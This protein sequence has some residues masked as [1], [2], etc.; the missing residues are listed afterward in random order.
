[1]YSIILFY[2]LSYWIG[3]LN[4]IPIGPV[5]LEIFHTALK[6][7][8]PQALA[9]AF[10]GALGDALWALLAFYGISP[11]SKSHKMEAIFF[12]ITAIITFVLGI[13]ILRDS[14][15]MTRKEEVIVVKIRSKKW[16]FFKG[17]SLIL[18]NPLGIVFWMIVLQF[19]RKMNIYIPLKLNYEIFFFL[20]VAAGAASY[21]SLIVLITNKMKE[22]FNPRR[23]V[24]IVKYLG[25]GL[26][27]LSAYFLFN[28]VKVFFFNTS[29]LPIK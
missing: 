18:V 21:F 9:V 5:N 23:T 2:I 8:Y 25:Y 27:V 11:F 15:F 4:C 6:K 19:L 3:F 10:G 13:I 29:A 12:L 28:A 7:Q 17:L 1:M 20:V 24:K 16:A 14:K 26:F 22:F